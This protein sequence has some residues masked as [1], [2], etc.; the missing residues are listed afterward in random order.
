M[1]GLNFPLLLS[2]VCATLA[3]VSATITD[4][5]QLSFDENDRLLTNYLLFTDGPQC[6]IAPDELDYRS[7]EAISAN[8]ASRYFGS[9]PAD[10]GNCA[11]VCLQ[12]G[13]HRDHVFHPL[14]NYVG[15]NLSSVEYFGQQ[16]CQPTEVGFLSHYNNIANIYWVNHR[17]QRVKVGTLKKGERNTIWQQSHLG[18][19]FIV[20]DSVTL[21][22]L[23]DV[24][25]TNDAVYPIGELKSALQVRRC[26]CNV[27]PILH[28]SC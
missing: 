8:I 10:Y 3:I 20:E 22:T 28:F 24:T 19:R 16:T 11:A 15:T 9:N 25:L 7:S 17:N 12:K 21:A 26:F 6:N 13:T 2:V 18:H 5:N 14:P 4:V 23:L 1:A 27:L